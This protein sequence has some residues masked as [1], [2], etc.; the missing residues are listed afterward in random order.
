MLTVFCA[1]LKTAPFSV[2]SSIFISP[3]PAARDGVRVL[4]AGLGAESGRGGDDHQPGGTGQE[5][6]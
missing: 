4:E 1:V 3:G 5:E 6:V 2:K